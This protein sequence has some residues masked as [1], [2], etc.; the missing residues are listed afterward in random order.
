MRQVQH[1]QPDHGLGAVVAVLVPQAG[2]REDQVAAAHRALLAVH[3][4]PGAFALD[5]HAHRV[6]CVAVAGRPFAGQQQLHA[7]VHGGAGLHVFQAVAGV[8]QH[9]HAAL[10]LFHRGQL[11]GRIS[12]GRSV[13]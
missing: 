12:S 6:G 11:A 13:S 7:Q 3:R 1:V 8:G 4:G 9:Q 2:G 5:D 10:G